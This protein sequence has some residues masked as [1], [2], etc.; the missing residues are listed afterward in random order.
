MEGQALAGAA[1]GQLML[2]QGLPGA[3]V[4]PSEAF[5]ADPTMAQQL[6]MQQMQQQMMMGM[7]MA[8]AMGGDM[9]G[10]GMQAMGGGY[11][12]GMERVFPCVKLRGLPFDITEDDVRLFLVCLVSSLCV[13]QHT[14]HPS[15]N[16]MPRCEACV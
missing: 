8:G 6:Q 16:V 14:R 11:G 10:M 4:Y 7:G 3:E 2:P 13:L 5:P 12:M 1:Q 9:Q 15:V